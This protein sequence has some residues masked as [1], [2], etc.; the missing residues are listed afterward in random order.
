MAAK[1]EENAVT[2]DSSVCNTA[3]PGTTSS[4]HLTKPVPTAVAVSRRQTRQPM[5][6]QE[7]TGIINTR[8]AV[9]AQRAPMA[10]AR[11]PPREPAAVVGQETDCQ[12]KTKFFVT[13]RHGDLDGETTVEEKHSYELK[14]NLIEKYLASHNFTQSWDIVPGES[15]LTCIVDILKGQMYPTICSAQKETQQC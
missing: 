3:E 7:H 14:K 9:P 8:R 11:P 5:V 2:P 6:Q 10:P 12:G 15:I 4:R 1:H 13:N